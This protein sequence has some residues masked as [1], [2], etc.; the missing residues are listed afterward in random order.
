MVF[1]AAGNIDDK[2]AA[3]LFD[4]FFA[5]VPGEKNERK[6]AELADFTAKSSLDKREIEQVHLILSTI[7]GAASSQDS[8][9]L[10]L[11]GYMISGGMS[12]PL[13]QEIRDKRGLC[14]EIHGGLNKWSDFSNFNIY[15]GTDPK[16]YKEAIDATLEVIEKSKS[17]KVLME[18]AKALRIGRLALNFENM[19]DVIGIAARD[20]TFLGVPRGYEQI[21]SEIEK[22]TIDDVGKSVDKYFV[23]DKVC[24]SMLVPQGFKE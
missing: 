2:S 21:K 9:N 8:S 23:K 11:F 22:V 1:V 4:E 14:Y 16:R 13:F 3:D 17:D 10:E 5:F 7:A 15:I 12:F 18:R 19:S 24:R 20:I 6:T